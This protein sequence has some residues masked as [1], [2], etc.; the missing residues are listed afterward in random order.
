MYILF[1]S[2]FHSY[3]YFPFIPLCMLFCVLCIFENP[4]W[5][6]PDSGTLQ[7][8]Q[9]QGL[10]ERKMGNP[11]MRWSRTWALETSS[12]SSVG[13]LLDLFTCWFSQSDKGN[14]NIFLR[15]LVSGLGHNMKYLAEFITYSKCSI[16]IN[17]CCRNQHI[18]V[19]MWLF[20]DSETHMKTH[21][22]INI[23]VCG[24]N[25]Q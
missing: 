24:M 2:R 18:W 17:Y 12:L 20:L 19:C 21:A 14:K 23:Q 25:K 13:M 4:L 9:E 16:N 11:A 7:Y 22:H 1:I 15:G 8:I 3:S 6:L 5:L 10:L